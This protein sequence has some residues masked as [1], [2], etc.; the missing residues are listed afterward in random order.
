MP[1]CRWLLVRQLESSHG[2]VYA[3]GYSCVNPKETCKGTCGDQACE[4]AVVE[5]R[6]QAVC[7]DARR[8][9]ELKV[10]QACHH[11]S[12]CHTHPKMRKVVCYYNAAMNMRSK[13][14]ECPQG[15]FVKHIYRC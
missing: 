2:D 9:Q 8:L 1:V 4:R 5:E 11:M 3:V 14:L 7:R 6:R 15:A 12:T 13:Q 10:L